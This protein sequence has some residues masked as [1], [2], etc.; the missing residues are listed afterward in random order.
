MTSQEHGVPALWHAYRQTHG[1]ADS[2]G[3]DEAD[4]QTDGQTDVQTATPAGGLLMDV[5][6]VSQM[7]S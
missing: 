5:A 3:D 6:S 1:D 2:D 7:T 4:G